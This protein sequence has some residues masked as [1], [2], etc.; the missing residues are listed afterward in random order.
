MIPPRLLAA[1]NPRWEFLGFRSHRLKELSLSPK[2]AFIVTSQTESRR[3]KITAS[4]ISLKRGWKLENSWSLL[5]ISPRRLSVFFTLAQ[6]IS[7]F[8]HTFSPCS[9]LLT[10]LSC[11]ALQRARRLQPW[12]LFHT[13]R[14]NITMFWLTLSSTVALLLSVYIP[15]IFLQLHVEH[16]Y[17]NSW[18]YPLKTQHG[19]KAN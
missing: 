5:F 3:G 1:T 18:I 2:K 19:F 7:E 11:L 13:E 12:Q 4:V 16:E 15:S 8:R 14:A 17:N 10:L 6:F 9:C